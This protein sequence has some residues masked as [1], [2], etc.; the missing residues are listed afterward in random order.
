MHKLSPGEDAPAV[1]DYCSHACRTQDCRCKVCGKDL[2]G[3]PSN[4]APVSEFCGLGCQVFYL[5]AV[6]IKKLEE[7]L[8]SHIKTPE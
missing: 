4:D 3:E 1:V 7:R 5:E 8:D 2:W 6:T